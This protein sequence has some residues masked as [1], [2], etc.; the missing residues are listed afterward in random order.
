MSGLIRTRVVSRS[1]RVDRLSNGSQ[2]NGSKAGDGR[3]SVSYELLRSVGNAETRGRRRN[4]GHKLLGKI[5]VGGVSGNSLRGENHLVLRSLES[6]G[7]IFDRSLGTSARSAVR[8]D[9]DRDGLSDDDFFTTDG[10]RDRD[11]MDDWFVDDGWLHS[12][13]GLVN[14]AVHVFEH[15]LGSGVVVHDGSVG[16]STFGHDRHNWRKSECHSRC[17]KN[18]SIL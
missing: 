9:V 10:R 15:R 5:L 17:R 7:R 1:V 12:D 6:L 13:S 8:R 14:D 16:D 11:M 18:Q 4:G 2:G 3:G